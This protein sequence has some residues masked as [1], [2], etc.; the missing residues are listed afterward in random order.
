MKFNEVF[1]KHYGLSLLLYNSDHFSVSAVRSDS[2]ALM[3]SPRSS[4]GISDIICGQ[5][6]R[7]EVAQFSLLNR[8]RKFGTQSWHF[9][10]CT[11]CPL[12]HCPF[13]GRGVVRSAFERV[14]RSGRTSSSVCRRNRDSFL[15][16][17]SKKRVVII[18]VR[19]SCLA[20]VSLICVLHVHLLFSWVLKLDDIQRWR[21]DPRD[22]GRLV[23]TRHFA[24]I[25]LKRN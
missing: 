8:R 5:N 7:S 15:W 13:S 9:I 24:R 18:P 1:T 4:R 17:C 23:C 25:A 2:I 3:R 20:P 19:W 10:L 21:A 11:E 12:S 22:L 16:I 6:S 14:L